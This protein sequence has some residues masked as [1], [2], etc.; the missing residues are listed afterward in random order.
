ML[1]VATRA[2]GARARRIDDYKIDRRIMR[3]V[4]QGRLDFQH[5]VI[6]QRIQRIGAVEGDAP[7]A[8][9]DSDNDISHLY[10]RPKLRA[11]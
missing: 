6:G 11:Q 2:K 4:A 5:H 9:G 7:G 3:P 8:A 1:D 10:A